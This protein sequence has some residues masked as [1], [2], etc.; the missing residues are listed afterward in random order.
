MKHYSLV[1]LVA[2]LVLCGGNAAGFQAPHSAH[3]S[4]KGGQTDWAYSGGSASNIHYSKLSQ[5]NKENVSRLREAWRFDTNEKGGLE[6]T[7]L[8]VGGVLYGYTPSQK[9]FALDASTGKLLWTFDS[10]KA[11]GAERIASRAERSM[12]FWHSGSQ[13]RILAGISHCIYAIDPA[14]GKLIRSF[15]NNGRIDLRENLGR[16]PKLQAVSITSPG[17]IYRDLIIVGDAEPET[18]PSP[19][20]DIRAY[21]VRTGKMQWIFHTIPHPGEFG[22]DTWPPNAW[23]YT[24]SANNW[25]GMAVDQE[26]GIV[27][28][29]TGSAA[30]DKYGADRVGDDLF[31]DCLLAL[32][33]ET[34]KRIWH[35]QGIRHDLW[36]W[37]FPAPPSLV[38]VTHNGTQVPAVVQTS[39]QGLL[40]VFNRMTGEPLFPIEERKVPASDVPG[41]VTAATQPIPTKPAPYAEQRITEDKL[42]TRTPEAHQSAV[43]Q[44]RTLHYEGLFT[45]KKVGVMSLEFPG[46]DGG[47]EWGGSTFD[48]ETHILYVNANNIGIL[49]SL[50]KHTGSRGRQIYMSQCSLCHRDNLA[51]SP[52]ET[53]SL[54]DIGKRL[55]PT[56]IGASIQSGKG[57]MPP[58]P[59]L[60]PAKDSYNSLIS[61]LVAGEPKNTPDAEEAKGSRVQYDSTG[62]P[63]FLDPEGYPAN[64]TPWGTLNAINLDTGE[65]VWRIPFGQY[66][67]LVAQGMQDTGSENYGGSVVTAGGVL[68]IGA[69]VRDKK[70]R[71]YDKDTG[72][73]LWE[74]SLPFSACATP[75]VYEVNGREYVVIAAGGQRDPD[76]PAGGG[77]YLAFALHR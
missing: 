55:T 28:V 16:D 64:A 58:F 63:K 42:T 35:F 53:P 62:D 9:V 8:I 59:N 29:P 74:S 36:D 51:G 52:P 21:N 14:N 7:P 76:T 32:D 19:P 47:G 75:A 49:E 68:F 50:A 11:F 41:E 17:V 5:I 30:T 44:F 38:T 54:I 26:R 61:Y 77:V 25:A 69:T 22:Y 6:T 13:Q 34:G 31:S 48:P 60:D 56:Q 12:A 66:P 57:R 27:Y 33:A 45:P 24:G 37:D 39:K 18:L 15:G 71:A 65:Y 3:V 1:H 2:L 70:M 4:A 73:L 40:F 43:K 20:G 67:E 10:Q 72:K 23:T 46:N